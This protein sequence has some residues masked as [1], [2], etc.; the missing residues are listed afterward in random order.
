VRQRPEI[1][2][3]VQQAGHLI[4]NHT[5]THPSLMWASPSR[6]RE[7]LTTCTAVIEDVTGV[8]AGYFRP[9]FGTRRPDV[10]LIARELGLTPVMWNVTAHDWDATDP[11]ALTAKVQRIVGRNQEIGRGSNVLLHDGG[12]KHLGVDRSVTV[13][14]TGML[15]DGW[16][17]NGFRYVTA[18][19]WG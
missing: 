4:G 18:D 16:A 1:A 2:R 9:P 7:E 6:V 10:L 12:H 17:G 19:A 13:A 5:V 11:H 8:R 15:L 14:T 3:A